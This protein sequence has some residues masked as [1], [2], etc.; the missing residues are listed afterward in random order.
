MG[1]FF[2]RDY[3]DCTKMLSSR[4]IFGQHIVMLEFVYERLGFAI[5]VLYDKIRFLAYQRNNPLM[6]AENREKAVDTK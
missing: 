2:R 4:K 6:S 5:Y 1:R 3:I